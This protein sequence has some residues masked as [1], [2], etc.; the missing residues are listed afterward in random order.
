[1]VQWLGLHYTV[2]GSGLIP[3]QGTKI[4][5]HPCYAAWSKNYRYIYDI[6]IHIYIYIYTKQKSR[7]LSVKHAIHIKI[8][9]EIFYMLWFIL[10]SK[11][12]YVFHMQLLPIC[13][14]HVSSDQ[15]PHVV[16]GY[17]PEQCSLQ[18]F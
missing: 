12:M 1:M 8:V 2:E 16:S 7:I 9:N 3:S 11:A 6:Y 15:E 4:L 14:C 17:H 18:L 13:T 10:P 5:Q